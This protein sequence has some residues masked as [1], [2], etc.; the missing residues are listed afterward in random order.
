MRQH[1]KL[2]RASPHGGVC[3]VLRLAGG[4]EQAGAHHRPFAPAGPVDIIAGS[5]AKLNEALGSNS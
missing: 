2:F 3:F 5:G 1:K 4:A